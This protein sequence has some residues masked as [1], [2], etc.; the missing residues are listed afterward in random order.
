MAGR[1]KK[2]EQEKEN[3][4]VKSTVDATDITNITETE[5]TTVENIVVDGNGANPEDVVE[6]AVPDENA[7]ILDVI[8]EGTN[9]P[10]VI[11]ADDA[12]TVVT[13][14]KGPDYLDILTSDGTD[15]AD[16][17]IKPETI[18][19]KKRCAPQTEPKTAVVAAKRF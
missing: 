19:A 5:E 12:E 9:D 3:I 4:D 14:A 6:I 17:F 18:V 1:S 2:T 16:M 8:G 11:K 7:T 13:T 15:G 10:G